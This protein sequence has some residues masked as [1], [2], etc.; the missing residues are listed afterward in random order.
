MRKF[1][2]LLIGLGIGWWL[3]TNPEPLR[4]MPFAAEPTPTPAPLTPAQEAERIVSAERIDAGDLARAFSLAPRVAASGLAG[5]DVVVTGTVLDFV[6]GGVEADIVEIAL[7][8]KSRLKV[9]LRGDEGRVSKLIQV[10]PE[11]TRRY[12]AR[13]RELVT[14]L[15]GENPR[16]LVT[17]SQVTAIRVRFWNFTGSSITMRVVYEDDAQQG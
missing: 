10:Q 16:V 11:P 4:V 12:Y 17:Q 5:R 8:T 1:V 7:Q 13:G 2:F 9:L 6:V 15:R 3:W 14:K